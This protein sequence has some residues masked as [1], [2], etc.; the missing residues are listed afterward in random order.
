MVDVFAS[1]KIKN[2][3]GRLA[4][5]YNADSVVKRLLTH[6]RFFPIKTTGTVLHFRLI[7]GRKRIFFLFRER[8]ELARYSEIPDSTGRQ[9]CNKACR[10]FSPDATRFNS[11]DEKLVWRCRISCLLS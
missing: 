6:P 2:F 7:I 1:D 4:M 10:I 9:H 3:S 11:D 8:A 5:L